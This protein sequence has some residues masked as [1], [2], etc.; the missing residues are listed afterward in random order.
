M[1]DTNEALRRLVTQVEAGTDAL[2]GGAPARTRQLMA[3]AATRLA[4]ETTVVSVAS[5]IGELGLSA[6][7]AQL[8]GQPDLDEHDDAILELGFKRL[9]GEGRT[10]L[11]VLAPEGV[12]RSALRYLQH[13]A[14]HL[15]R[16]TMVVHDSPALATTL[17]EP[18]LTALRDRLHAAPRIE[19]AAAPE[20]VPSVALVVV[21]SADIAPVATTPLVGSA[22]PGLRLATLATPAR[23][24][25][26]WIGATLSAAAIA[27]IAYVGQSRPTG[28]V[29]G[30][31]IAHVDLPLEAAI[32]PEPRLANAAPDLAE[33]K[34][35]LPAATSLAP[36]ALAVQPQSVAAKLPQ[37]ALATPLP[38]LPPPTLAPPAQ[39]VPVQ[40]LP[41]LT[42]PHT[43]PVAAA[44]VQRV[45]KS[46][47]VPQLRRL[48]PNR[49]EASRFAQ[50]P[51][52]WSA[53]HYQPPPDY[54]A[55]RPYEEIPPRW[56]R[57]ERPEREGPY[58]GTFAMDPYGVRT[59]RYDP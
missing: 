34:P 10:T 36:P 59:F 31:T 42:P 39:P 13:V 48:D 4:V 11:M 2:V 21:P 1:G 25:A 15:P 19:V 3:E 47:R 56:V 54:E 51:P 22:R 45:A 52:Y 53:P 27:G 26:L 38:T 28:P 12:N 43:D 9:R 55:P 16:L 46:L 35:S 57:R 33:V 18:G 32:V 58:L 8:S 37:I 50:A 7:I 40:T 44:P 23:R 24:P 20:R 14:R 5:P 49:R 29:A 17:G 41:Q 6:L 30:T